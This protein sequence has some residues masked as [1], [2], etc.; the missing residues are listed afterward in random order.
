VAALP[1]LVVAVLVWLL[2]LPGMRA[3]INV[4]HQALAG[5]VAGRIQAHL[6]GAQRELRAVGNYIEPREDW[7]A[8]YLSHLLDVHVGAGDVFEAIYMVDPSDRVSS[9]GLAQTRRGNRE[10]LLGLDLSQRSFL[11]EV[12][13]SRG[14]VWSETFLSTVSGRLAVALAVPLEDQV[15]IGEITID[16]LQEFISHLP[17]KSGRMTAILDRA[18]RVIAD[19]QRPVGGYLVGLSHLGPFAGERADRGATQEFRLEDRVYIGSVIPVPELGWTVLVAQSRGEAFRQITS[20]FWLVALGG[21]MAMLLAFGAGWLLSQVISRKVAHYTA[22]ARAIAQGNY[23]QPW[24][25]P[26]TQE[27]NDLADNLQRMSFAI[28]AREQALAASEA[29]YRFIVGNTPVAIFEFDDQG[30]FTLSE[31]RGLDALGLKPGQLVGISVFEFYSQDPE[32]GEYARRAI[33]GESLRFTARVGASVFETY[34]NPV[35]NQNTQRTSV[36]GVAVDITERKRREEELQQRTDELIR[37][38]YAVSHDLRTPLVTIRS[39]VGFLEKDIRNQDGDRIAKDFYYIRH[40]AEKM[41]R[42]L[43]D[44]L[45]LARVGRQVNPPVEVT[46]QDLVE[47]ALKLLAGPITNR[48]VTVRVSKISVWISGDRPRLVEAFQ[49]LLDNAVKFMGDQAAP[50]IDV[51]VEKAESEVVLFVRD[52]GIGIDPRFQHKLFGLFEKLEPS[53]EGSGVGLA[54]VKRIVEVHGGRIW[55]ESEGS[56]HGTTFRFT[57]AGTKCT[58]TS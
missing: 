4:R 3:D 30:I 31:G 56:G 13:E 42:L 29:R 33:E 14:E 18:G 49:N 5:A 9:V 36:I 26:S 6:L 58:V 12:R 47:E 21:A 41:S 24:P 50:R 40:A 15:L 22:Q 28:R 53:L 57:L 32:L 16:R 55:V 52:N 8:P 44:L 39:F 48:A 27:F 10:D 11:R 38:T 23:E 7:K 54:L 19:S 51:G 25:A 35:R 46:L 45:E 17:S 1:L 20:T 2:L 37:F 43:D 34:Y